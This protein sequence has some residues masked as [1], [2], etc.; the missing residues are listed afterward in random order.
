MSR[1][2][3]PPEVRLKSLIARERLMPKVLKDARANLKNPPKIYTEIAIEQIPGIA[4]FFEN[5]VPL[6]FKTGDRPE[7]AGRISS[8]RTRAVIAALK[9][10]EAVSEERRASAVERRF[11]AGRGELREEAGV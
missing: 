9:D 3:A 5:D 6:A 2:F 10:Y 11:P 7:A 8:S 4:A 1:T